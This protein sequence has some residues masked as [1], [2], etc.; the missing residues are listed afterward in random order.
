MM[1][2]SDGRFGVARLRT[3]LYFVLLTVLIASVCQGL[4]GLIG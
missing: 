3:V 4:A 2:Y 1:A